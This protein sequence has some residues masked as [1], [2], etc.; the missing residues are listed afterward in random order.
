MTIQITKPEVEALIN[1][2]LERGAFR[3]AEDVIFAGSSIIRP[4]GE[5]FRTTGSR[6]DRAPDI[7]KHSGRRSIRELREQARP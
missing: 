6:S 1:Q 7:R 2:R 4:P 5:G 3:G